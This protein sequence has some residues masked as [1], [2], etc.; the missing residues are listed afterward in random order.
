MLNLT[1]SIRKYRYLRITMKAMRTFTGRLGYTFV[2]TK[3]ISGMHVSNGFNIFRIEVGRD[4]S[5]EHRVIALSHELGHAMD[6]ARTPMTLT[7]KSR[8]L[9]G[10]IG[11]DT[12]VREV[13]AWKNAEELLVNMN[14]LRY[15][16]ND[17]A[18]CKTHGLST[19]VEAMIRDL[20]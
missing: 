13:E 11:L 5:L 18:E 8:S 4:Q 14:C 16:E 1:Y 19:Y 15:I 17:F 12:L 20:H 7:E 10:T 3:G 6:F 2:Y 9:A